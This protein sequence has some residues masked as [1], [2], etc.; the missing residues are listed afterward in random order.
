MPGYFES[1]SFRRTGLQGRL[2]SCCAFTLLQ[3][4]INTEFQEMLKDGVTPP[5]VYLH[6]QPL[7]PAKIPHCLCSVLLAN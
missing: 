1:T 7:C 3:R 4:Q 2:S 5:L 6:N